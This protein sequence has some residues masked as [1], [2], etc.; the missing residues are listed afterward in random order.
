MMGLFLER[1]DR[2]EEAEKFLRQAYEERKR[3][4]GETHKDIILD[5]EDLASVQQRRLSHKRANVATKVI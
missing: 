3:V 4:L 1:Q 2:L 5:K